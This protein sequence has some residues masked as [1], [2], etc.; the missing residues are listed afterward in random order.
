MLGLAAEEEL[1]IADEVDVL[2][3]ATAVVAVVGAVVTAVVE[4]VGVLAL[5]VVDDE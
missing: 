3:G 1:V 5:D 4:W 2:L